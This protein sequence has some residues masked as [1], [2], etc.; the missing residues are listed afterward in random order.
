MAFQANGPSWL[1]IEEHLCRR[2]LYKEAALITS[3]VMSAYMR[4]VVTLMT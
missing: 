3:K 2:V 4:K 1:F